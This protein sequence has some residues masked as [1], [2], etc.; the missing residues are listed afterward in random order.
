M[1]KLL[2]HAPTEAALQRALANARNLLHTEPDAQLQIVVNARA[3]VAA[4][5]IDD[6]A[7]RARLVVCANSL[8]RAEVS[9]PTDLRCVQAAVLHVAHMQAEGWAYWRA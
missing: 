4:L 2:I 6:V 9:P 3:A 5:D 7:L 1:L 8:A